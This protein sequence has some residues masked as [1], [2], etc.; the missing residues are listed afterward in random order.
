V[1]SILS[2]I[3]QVFNKNLLKPQE[4]APSAGDREVEQAI[5][6]VAFAAGQ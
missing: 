5:A 4:T 2:D 3:H 1:T 6:A